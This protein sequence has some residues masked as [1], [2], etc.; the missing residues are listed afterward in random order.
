[1]SIRSWPSVVC[2]ALALV[3]VLTLSPK[4]RVKSRMMYVMRSWRCRERLLMCLNEISFLRLG[5]ERHL[6]ASVDP[7]RDAVACCYFA[8]SDLA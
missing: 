4:V 1:M 5:V 8:Y 7:D 6:Q 2:N 3:P